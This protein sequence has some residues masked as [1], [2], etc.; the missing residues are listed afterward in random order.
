MDLRKI[1][2]DG[3]TIEVTD[4]GAQA[5]EKLQKQLGDTSAQLTKA[6]TEHSSAIAAKDKELATKDAELEK[7]KK[8]GGSEKLMDMVSELA[9]V[10][11]KS[12]LV[13]DGIEFKGKSLSEIRKMTVAKVLGDEA[14]KGKSDDYIA[15]RFDGLVE[16]AGNGDDNGDDRSQSFDRGGR[17]DPIRDG[18]RDGEP[19]GKNTREAAF[20]EN[21][22]YLSDAWKGEKEARS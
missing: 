21:I 12:K 15:A 22:S 11:G 6:T 18:F 14:I 17:R 19:K 16:D 9:E 7:L 4:A 13:A 3:I 2:F 1:V 10:I 5:I 20:D 8:E